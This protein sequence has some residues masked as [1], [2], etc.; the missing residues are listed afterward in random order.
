MLDTILEKGWLLWYQ[1]CF[2]AEG[3]LIGTDKSKITRKQSKRESYGHGTEEYKAEAKKISSPS[4][5]HKSFTN[6]FS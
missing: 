5:S 6:S 2:R 3:Q 4:Q 1:G